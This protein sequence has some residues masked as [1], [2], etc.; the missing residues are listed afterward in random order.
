MSNKEKVIKNIDIIIYI[1]VICYFLDIIVL[2]GGDLTRIFG[3]SSKMISF[4]VAVLLSGVMILLDLKNYITNKTLL[5]VAGF[6]IIVVINA[7]R[8][9][10]VGD[11]ISM[12]ILL[13]DVKGFLNFLMVIPMVYILNSKERVV[14]LAKICTVVLT[15]L[16]GI[17]ILLCF[18]RKYPESIQHML[19]NFLSE[20]TI[21]GIA[22]LTRNTVR[23]F[24]HTASR[25]FF[26]GFL[27]AL[28]FSIL[29]KK[30]TGWMVSMVLQVLAIIL[31]FTRS[32]YL[33]L[34]LAAVALA[35]IVFFFCKE[36]FENFCKRVAVM[37]IAVVCATVVISVIQ[38]ENVFA[39]AINRCILGITTESPGGDATEDPGETEDTE[40]NILGNLES[41][42]ANLTI[43]QIR[44]ETALKN[45]SK[46]P[47]LGNG[48]GTINDPN[49]DLIEYF[50]LDLLSK[51]GI[52]GFLIFLLPFAIA[53][54][55]IWKNMA[56]YDRGQK[57]IAL[58]VW[59]MVVY[60][61]I[62]SY[63]NPCMNTTTG[64]SIY[65]MLLGV[66]Q[67]WKN[68]K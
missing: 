45:I 63:F 35:V 64:L 37:C 24:F 8:G 52:V 12:A 53:S 16:A 18:Y 32:I 30:K 61:L 58:C 65:S 4:A 5:A 9:I 14:K 40:E 6:M 57:I 55:F 28:G 19:Y 11:N 27:F 21:C 29:E 43:R 67:P 59:S 17:V 51:V 31:S 33:G 26:C 25:L 62:I 34:F 15:V 68:N 2:G 66:V 42:Q 1:A 10:L 20:N 48:L 22:G 23:V 54:Y 13:S 47:I 39:V 46:N 7:A 50:Y 56:V 44:T 38:G 3:I 41:E 36:E 60:L 49:G